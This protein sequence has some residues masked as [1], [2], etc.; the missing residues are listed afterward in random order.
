M[1]RIMPSAAMNGVP[2]NWIRDSLE[3][4]G[5]DPASLPNHRSAMPDGVQPWRDLYSAGHSVGLIDQIEPVDTLVSRLADEFAALVPG[6][7]W[8]ERLAVIERNWAG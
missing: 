7:G 3:A 4:A 1:D 5:I 6:D 8:R 2:A